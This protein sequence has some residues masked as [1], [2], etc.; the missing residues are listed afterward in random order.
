MNTSYVLANTYA[1]SFDSPR[2][3]YLKPC[4]ARLYAFLGGGGLPCGSAFLKISQKRPGGFLRSVPINGWPP[5]WSFHDDGQWGALL[6]SIEREGER[7]RPVRLDE[8]VGGLPGPSGKLCREPCGSL[9]ILEG[10]RFLEAPLHSS[11][12]SA[13]IRWPYRSAVAG[14]RLARS[15]WKVR[16]LAAR[17][18]ESHATVAGGSVP[19]AGGTSPKKHAMPVVAAGAT[20]AKR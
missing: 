7:R 14:A 8:T 16:L 17:R 1:I 20:C 19:G 12:L 10:H 4:S 11:R 18:S 5:P 3:C 13:A 2:G 9:P 6:L 15:R